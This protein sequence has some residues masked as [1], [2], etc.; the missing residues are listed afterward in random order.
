MNLTLDLNLALNSLTVIGI[1][2]LLKNMNEV[3]K[4]HAKIKAWMEGH[5]KQDDER[6]HDINKS[7]DTL[8]DKINTKGK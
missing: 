5:D 6:H 4:S 1:A 7:I 2:W 8:W 3:Q